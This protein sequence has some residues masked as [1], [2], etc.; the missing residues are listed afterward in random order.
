MVAI[1]YHRILLL[2]ECAG[3]RSILIV[4]ISVTFL[5]AGTQMGVPDLTRIPPLYSIKRY[6]PVSN[7]G[8]IALIVTECI[9]NDRRTDNRHSSGCAIRSR[10]DRRS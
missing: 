4:R 7:D 9:N 8:A 10:T 1:A 2:A 5:P 6:G 3:L